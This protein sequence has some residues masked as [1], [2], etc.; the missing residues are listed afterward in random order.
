MS[1]PFIVCSSATPL[2]ALFPLFAR[3]IG[4]N[5]APCGLLAALLVFFPV[6]V[7]TRSGLD[8]ATPP[9]IDVVDALGGQRSERFRLRRAPCRGTPHRQRLP[10]RRRLGGHRCRR[11]REPHRPRGLGVEFAYSYRLLDLPRAFGAA[12]VIVVLSVAVF[13]ARRQGSSEPSTRGGPEPPST[14]PVPHHREQRTTMYTR[15]ALHQDIGRRPRRAHV[16]VVSAILAAC[17]DDDDDSRRPPTPPAR[18]ARPPPARRRDRHDDR[19]P[20]T[21][22]RRRPPGAVAHRRSTGCPT[23]SGRPGTSPRTAATSPLA[24]SSRAHPRRPERAAVPQVLAA[25]DGNIGISAS[26]LD[27]IS[28]N[29]EGP[30]LRDPR[31]HVPAQ[32]ARPDVDGRD[33]ASRRSRTSSASGSAARRATRC[34]STPCSGSTASSPTT[35]FVPMSFD[36]QP[37]ADGEMDAIASLRHQPADPAAARRATTS[38]PSRTPTSGCRRT[39]TSSSRRRRG[40]TENQRPRRRSTSPACS[41]ASTPTSTT[42]RRRC[43]SCRTR[44]GADNEIDPESAA[45]G[46]PAYIGLMTSPFTDANGLLSVD[47]ARMGDEILPA[48]ETA[49]ATVPAVD[50]ILD[51]TYLATAHTLS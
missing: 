34:R 33:A 13:S 6:F 47:P 30:G 41:K 50:E 31:R 2:F 10:H 24:A 49:G 37:L 38:A 35:T 9:M 1:V 28:A 14:P 36:P 48:L 4:Y 3:V 39:A 27:I 21:R 44:Y 32:P 43:R 26:E 22:A 46:N 20:T 29:A 11:R 25:G 40:S 12:I 51:T 23:S 7:F 15:R 8:A 18:P 45:L 5:D 16:P 19:R 42:R 17:G